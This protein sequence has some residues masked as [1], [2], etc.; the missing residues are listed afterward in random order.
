LGLERVADDRIR[1][2]NFNLPLQ[3][4]LRDFRAAERIDFAAAVA[5][6]RENEHP[7]N[8]VLIVERIISDDDPSIIVLD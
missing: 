2:T 8:V 6:T 5:T 3:T 4:A 1:I 7:K